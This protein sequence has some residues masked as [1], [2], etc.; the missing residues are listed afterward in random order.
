MNLRLAGSSQSVIDLGAADYA[1]VGCS[2]VD[3][4]PLTNPSVTPSIISKPL[5]ES[6]ASERLRLSD[7]TPN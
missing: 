2:A 7:D 6:L 3:I 5:N 4:P 1:A